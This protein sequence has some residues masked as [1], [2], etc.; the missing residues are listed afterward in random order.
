MTDI[1]MIDGKRAHGLVKLI[2][3][4]RQK[5]LD[6]HDPESSLM[7]KFISDIVKELKQAKKEL[8]HLNKRLKVKVEVG[9]TD[10]IETYFS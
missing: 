1:K 2:E 4:L 5:Y 9:K 3:S 8:E 10:Y 6:A 7:K